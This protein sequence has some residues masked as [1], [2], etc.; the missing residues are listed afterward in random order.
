MQDDELL[1]VSGYNIGKDDAIIETNVVA[2]AKLRSNH[3]S[4][5]RPFSG[6]KAVACRAVATVDQFP[7]MAT[8]S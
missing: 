3:Q 7:I 2:D 8:L 4:K 1:I 6:V 5:I